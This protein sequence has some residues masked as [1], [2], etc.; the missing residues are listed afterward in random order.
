MVVGVT[1]GT[2]SSCACIPVVE[3]AL[4]RIFNKGKTFAVVEDLPM[5]HNIAAPNLGQLWQLYD[6]VKKEV[7]RNT[8]TPSLTTC[9][10]DWADF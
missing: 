2:H 8:G 7:A 10:A 6:E 9:I 5:Y 3:E 4:R 1:S